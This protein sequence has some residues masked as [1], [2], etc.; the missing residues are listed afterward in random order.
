M[1]TEFWLNS[2]EFKNNLTVDLKK[3]SIVVFVGPNNS[4]KSRTLREIFQLT[5]GQK[6]NIEILKSLKVSASG[7]AD[8]FL[9]LIK[10]RKKDGSYRYYESSS[11]T[12]MDAN[13]LKGYWDS[14]VGGSQSSVGAISNFLVKSMD[15]VRRLS[16]VS[17]PENIDIMEEMRTHAIHVLKEDTDKELQF[18]KYFEQAFGEE[19][20]VNHGAGKKIPLHVGERPIVTAENDRVSTEYQKKLRELPFLHEQGDGMKSFAG[21]FLSLFAEDFLVNLI[22]EPEAFLH[23]PQAMLL[24]HMISQKLGN[25][26]QFFIATH[27]EHF[28]KGLLESAVDRLIVVRI[29][30]SK[31]ANSVKVLNNTDLQNIWK[32]S[33]LRHSNI[34]DGLFHKR[35]ALV[36]SDSDCRFYS[37]ITSAIVDNEK[38]SSPDI[39]FIQSGGKHRFP[40]IIKALRE[41]EVPLTIIGDFDFYHDENPTKFVYES[42]GGD[43]NIIKSDFIKVKKAI[44]VK[45]PELETDKLK[46]EINSVFSS[47]SDNIIPE[48][49]IKDIQSLLKRSSP[50]SQAKASGKA[51]LPA[52]DITASF[53]KVQSAFK[54][55][56]LHIL[57]LGEIE[58][59]DKSV[60]GHG[61]KWVNK[62]L[63]KDLL[64][65]EELEE[66]RKFVNNTIL[67]S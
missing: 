54:E 4:G 30:R 57:E 23:P 26:K 40:V 8:D 46:E 36:E 20:I 33:I 1:K 59:F 6:Y 32:D 9:E 10:S 52:G 67:Q 18:S 63:E 45:R 21:L 16:L 64:L 22:D 65:S 42:L 13:A 11:N 12:G 19:V 5:K 55:K 7:T 51:Y 48:Q 29:E 3:D 37:A 50:W 53:N 31:S 17:P 41:L 61:P 39:L 58:A 47:F 60:G 28:L 34:L 49:K 44:D 2:L 25:D 35:V 62:V 15:T 43:W 14:L 56:N 27:S 24:G 66:A 38:I